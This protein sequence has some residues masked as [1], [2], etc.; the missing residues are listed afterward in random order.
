M[1]K[2]ILSN[3]EIQVYKECRRKW[4]N[5]YIL[6][7]GKEESIGPL[8]LGTRV[9][10]ALAN[11][12]EPGGDPN[13]ALAHYNQL[14]L[15][16]LAKITYDQVDEYQKE[17]K[18][19]FIM[20]EGYFEWIEEEGADAD[21]EI[22]E[23]EKE[24]SHKIY[25]SDAT[26]ELWE[27]TLLAKLDA[28]G[29][30]HQLGRKFFMDHKTGDGHALDLNEQVLMYA[31]LQRQL[32]P[33]D[34]VSY[35]IWNILRKVQRSARAKPPFYYRLEHEMSNLMLDNF[36]LRLNGEI[37]DIIE[38]RRKLEAGVDHRTACYPTPSRD[39]GWKCP[40]RNLCPMFDDGSYV[41]EALNA[42]FT[43]KKPYARYLSVLDG[44]VKDAD[45]DA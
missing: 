22:L 1:N 5:E 20:L 45:A 26:G 34:L 4:R 33:N 40:F 10:G 28:V 27:V 38:T 31:W 29:F 11:Y 16:D 35:A 32:N 18:L 39:C 6:G 42:L 19:G 3:S 9:H 14:V 15:E 8:A 23:P 12:Y 13:G 2:L 36:S 17:A 30:D 7:Y 24:L 37:S 43:T 44:E 25:V 21:I 41:D